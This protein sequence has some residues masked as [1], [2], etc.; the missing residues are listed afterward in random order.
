[1]DAE[2]RGTDQVGDD[3]TAGTPA[4]DRFALTIGALPE[5]A[6]EIVEF[7]ERYWALKEIDKV[8]TPPRARW[9]ETTKQLAS[10]SGFP[11]SRSYVLAAAGVRAVVAGFECPQCHQPFS[12][13]ARGSL[14]G[15]LAGGTPDR[16]VDCDT[17]LRTA[18]QREVN[19][20]ADRHRRVTQEQLRHR[21]VLATA[22]K[23]WLAAQHAYLADRY[24]VRLTPDARPSDDVAVR[25]E[26]AALAMLRHA[27]AV[28]PLP[29]VGRWSPPLAPTPSMSADLAADCYHAGLIAIHPDSEVAAFV[30]EP[31]F[32]EALKAA[33]ND[34]SALPTPNWRSFYPSAASW[35]VPHGT[36]PGVA[37][38]FLD[39][40]LLERLG[41]AGLGPDRID[42]L[43]GVLVEV[44]ASETLRY[45]AFQLDLHN[46]PDV[47]ENHTPRLV[48]AATRLASE[49][50]LAEAYNLA[51]NAARTAAATAQAT[52]QAPKIN[53]TTHA[54]NVFETKAQQFA[55][56]PTAPIKPYR[57]DH[58]VPL[59]ALTRTLFIA[60]LNSDMMT[61]T[62]AQAEA[63]LSGR[64]AAHPYS[65][66]DHDITDA[67]RAVLAAEVDG[68]PHQV[69]AALGRES[70]NPDPVI[71]AAVDQLV[72]VVERFRIVGYDLG[73][74][75]AGAINASPLLSTPANVPDIWSGEHETV[76]RAVG[77]YL[78]ELMR[79]AAELS[80]NSIR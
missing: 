9:Q 17:D 62:R 18:A 76:R 79:Q 53:M 2:G 7:G 3:T 43:L 78:A 54:V 42:E 52:P 58:R 29:P 14:D 67:M 16:C 75:L 37:A 26:L 33:D 65:D 50:S 64:A 24:A 45:F 73:G 1:M 31:S 39:Q 66:V 71:A 6:A 47:P 68:D 48:E 4:T 22:K 11:A 70:A 34:L 10:E 13:R 5:A 35:Y 61:T 28:T 46:L 63:I 23:D 69:Y 38:E 60:I 56:D 8:A 57:E 55:A 72:Q 40:Y 12:L 15:L 80:G 25:T 41:P 27:H 36:S 20:E 49:R 51:W 74:A 30:W 32:D 21:A 19:P 77:S 59:S 44:I